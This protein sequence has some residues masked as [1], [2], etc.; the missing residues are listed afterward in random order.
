MYPHDISRIAVIPAIFRAARLRQIIIVFQW[1]T[2]PDGI[3][4]RQGCG[5]NTG[6]QRGQS[7]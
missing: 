6:G 3:Y 1:L 4:M 2:N 5:K 7:L